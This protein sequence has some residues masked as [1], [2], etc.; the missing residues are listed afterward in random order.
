MKKVR[1]TEQEFFSLIKEE[2]SKALAIKSKSKPM[3]EDY[4][5]YDMGDDEEEDEMAQDSLG[6][7]EFVDIL[8]RNG[9]ATSNSKDVC[10]LVDGQRRYG[11]KYVVEPYSY[12]NK[13]QPLEKLVKDLKDAALDPNGVRVSTGNIVQAPEIKKIFVTIL[14]MEN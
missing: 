6:F 5:D 14:E 7:M 13:T 1:L 8:D 2:V 4:Y 10:I 3:N 9:W 11:T 12:N